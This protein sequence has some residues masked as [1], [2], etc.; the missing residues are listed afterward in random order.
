MC[1]L[2]HT[3]HY[4]CVD[5]HLVE[6]KASTP[7]TETQQCT[8]VVH[9]EGSEEVR[10]RS[11]VFLQSVATGRVLAPNESEARSRESLVAR[12]DHFGPWQRLVVEKPL[13]TVV[14]PRRPRRRSSFPG[15]TSSPASRRSV[16][17]PAGSPSASPRRCNTDTAPV[18]QA[19]GP[20][21]SLTEAM[22]E[23]FDDGQSCPAEQAHQGTAAFCAGIGAGEATSG[24]ISEAPTKTENRR[25]RRSLAAAVD[26]ED[27]KV[28][29]STDVPSSQSSSSNSSGNSIDKDDA[30]AKPLKAPLTQISSGN[31]IGN[32]KKDAEA[33]PL[34]R[35]ASDTAS[36]MDLPT[37]ARRRRCSKGAPDA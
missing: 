2:S 16:D 33:R 4:L 35:R 34:K 17:G 22:F 26:L 37:P 25:T 27:Q 11:V 7:L 20:R 14:T 24:G 32:D 23:A 12:W 30:V 18:C 8:F 21:R 10:H 13:S 28:T 19:R 5:G 36:F 15:L 31:C 6:A 3:G 29:E 9:T 1:L